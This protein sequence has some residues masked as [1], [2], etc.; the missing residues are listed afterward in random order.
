MQQIHTQ[1]TPSLFS[2]PD[3]Q[4]LITT[5]DIAFSILAEVASTYPKRSPPQALI[6]AGCLALGREP[7]PGYSGWGMLSDWGMRN[8]DGSIGDGEEYSG[9]ELAK[10][11]QEH[12]LLQA[13]DGNEMQ[14]IAEKNAVK[15]KNTAKMPFSVGQKIRIWPN[16]AC[17]AA[18]GFGF[19]AVVDSSGERPDEVVDVWVR[20]RGW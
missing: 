5:K 6:A 19:Y 7:C 18:A 8:D 4:S 10:V 3:S 16:H 13:S 15:Q 14:R 11:S 9:W 2:D 1:V 17:I 20:C 12:G